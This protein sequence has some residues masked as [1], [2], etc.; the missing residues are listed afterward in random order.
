MTSYREEA[1]S[2][3]ASLDALFQPFDPKDN[4]QIDVMVVGTKDGGIHLSI[5]DS[6]VIGC[7]ERPLVMGSVPLQVIMHTSRPCY[8]THSLLMKSSRVD[9]NSL[10]IVPMDLR[11]VSAS[12]NYLSLLAS[13]STTLQNLLR[14]L[15]QVQVL[16][17][18]EWN[19]ARELPAKFLLSI[20]EDLAA[21]GKDIVHALYH[22]ISTGHTF[23][24]VREWLVL[25]LAE[26]VGPCY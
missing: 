5:Y 8:S 4:D 11:F 19:A 14:Y 9:Q 13:K 16:M 17:L 1:F 23:P 25:H 7:F 22:S 20:N 2:S 21:D 24:L 3:R 6:F 15:H 10:Y 12:S 26:R 18:S